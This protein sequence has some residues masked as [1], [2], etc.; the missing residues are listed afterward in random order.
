MSSYDYVD[1]CHFLLRLAITGTETFILPK[2]ID[3]SNFGVI[4]AKSLHTKSY[5]V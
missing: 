1:G 2:A 4:V 5:I 3:G